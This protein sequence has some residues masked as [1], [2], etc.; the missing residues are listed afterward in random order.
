MGEA[1][2]SLDTV[3]NKIR[4]FEINKPNPNGNILMAHNQRRTV[5][6]AR[7]SELFLYVVGLMA[8][9]I[10][11]MKMNGLTKFAATSSA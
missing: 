6:K 7:R 8:Q 4:D 5:D 1:K 3:G 11:H 10:K 9:H 2:Y